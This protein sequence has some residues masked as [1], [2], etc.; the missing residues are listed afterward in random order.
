LLRGFLF[1]GEIIRD[2]HGVHE[3]AESLGRTRVRTT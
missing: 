2:G 3:G 1:S